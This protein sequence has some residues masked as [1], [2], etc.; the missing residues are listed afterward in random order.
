MTE[1]RSQL[2]KKWKREISAG[3]IVYKK[4]D[5]RVFVLMIMP[6]KKDPNDKKFTP[7]WTFPKGWIG[8]HGEETLE[9]AATREVREEGGVNAKVVSKLGE[10]KYFFNWQGENIFK[11]VHHYLL[12][13]KDGNPEDHDEEVSEAKWFDLEEAGKLLKYKSDRD[14]LAKAQELLK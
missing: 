2:R 8:D 6:T 12:E 14:I 7:S 9:Q 10:S 5:G 4:Q 3:G 13:Y 11:T 1:E